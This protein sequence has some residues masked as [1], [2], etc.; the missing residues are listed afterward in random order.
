MRTLL[1]I[2]AWI[3]FSLQAHAADLASLSNKDVIA[4]LKEALSQ[5]SSAAVAKLGVENGFLGNQR[6]KIPLPDKLQKIDGAMR[7]FGLGKYSDELIIS[8]NRA[9]EAAVPEAKTL[10]LDAVKKM[11]VQDA[12]GILTGGDDAATQYFRNKTESQ[13]R[14]KFLP[15]VTKT[16]RQ[17]GVVE[18][19]DEFTGKA[20]VLGLTDQPNLEQY[21]T[22]KALDGLFLMMKDEEK[23]IRS[24]PA[25]YSGKL[26]KK[27]FGAVS[28]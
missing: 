3:M 10:L 27:V 13:L 11:S 7:K 9:A 12:K 16:V 1:G 26:L 6:V 18:K 22:Q 19:Y 15:I 24:N 2:F 5:S 4:G 23:A 25:D 8:M 28:H 21:V 20:A 17:V 14:A